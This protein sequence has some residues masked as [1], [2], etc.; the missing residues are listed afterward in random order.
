MKIA[1]PYENGQVFQHFGHSGQ[2]KIYDVED[3][4]ITAERIAVPAGYSGR[5]HVSYKGFAV[6]RAAEAVSLLTLLLW[7]GLA[8]RRRFGGRKE[9]VHG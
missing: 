5:I 8:L 3:G 9:T 1:V 7:A 2:F 4:R 6:F